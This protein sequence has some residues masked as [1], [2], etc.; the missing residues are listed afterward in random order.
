MADAYR[1]LNRTEG[2]STVVEEGYYYLN[3]FDN[4]LNSFGEP[5]AAPLSPQAPEV[6]R[7]SLLNHWL[8]FCGVPSGP[9][10]GLESRPGRGLLGHQILFLCLKLPQ[11][12]GKDFTPQLGGCRLALERRPQCQPQRDPATLML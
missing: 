9:A 11:F 3:N 8:P 12:G 6:A 4:I 2:N 1:W 7:L 5:G 10:G